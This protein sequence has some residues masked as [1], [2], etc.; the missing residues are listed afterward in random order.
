MF[1]CHIDFWLCREFFILT[2]RSWLVN[3]RQPIVTFANLGQT[4]VTAL[5]VGIL[6]FH[7]SMSQDS[8]RVC[9]PLRIEFVQGYLSLKACFPCRTVKA[10]AFSSRQA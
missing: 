10:P 7:Q 8:V 4:I 5:L 3:I 6:Y 2:G 9:A 1:F